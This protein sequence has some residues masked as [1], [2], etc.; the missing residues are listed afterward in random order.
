MAN[1]AAAAA[2]SSALAPTATPANSPE[3]SGSNTPVK[4]SYILPALQ[5]LRSGL[6]YGAT[7]IRRTLYPSPPSSP[8]VEGGG[9]LLQK[10]TDLSLP[11]LA[12]GGPFHH[13]VGGVLAPRPVP[14]SPLMHLS[15]LIR[16][17]LPPPS[18][19]CSDLPSPELPSPGTRRPPL[20]SNHPMGMPG[21][22]GTGQLDRLRATRAGGPRRDLGMVPRP[23]VAD[24]GEKMGQLGVM[25]VGRKGG[26]L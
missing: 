2:S 22:P 13:S 15:K 16:G 18:E 10:V 21:E 9:Q 7:M 4:G 20:P 8:V 23:P 3:G 12:E 25:S 17:T 14:P 19:P 1:A 5:D 6:L 24:R 11:T 26:L